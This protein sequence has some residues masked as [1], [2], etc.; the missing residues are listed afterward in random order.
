MGLIMLVATVGFIFVKQPKKFDREVENDEEQTED[1]ENQPDDVM[2]EEKESFVQIL[3]NTLSLVVNPKMMKLN[4]QLV[5]TGVSISYWSGI[6]SPIVIFQLDNDPDYDAEMEEN[7][8][9]QYALLTM[10]SFG[11]GEVIGGFFMGWFLDRFNP[12]KGIITILIIIIVMIGITLWS[13]GIERYNF[14]TF[15]MSFAWGIQDGTINIH[16]MRT[17]GSEFKSKSEPFGVFNLVQ[18]ITVFIF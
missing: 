18:G 12:K 8:K 1:T 4:M 13:I 5:F 11:I 7:K 17:L 15:M 3:K 16:T 6:I 9:D 10:I 2:E 14:I